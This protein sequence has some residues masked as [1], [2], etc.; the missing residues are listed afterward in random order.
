MSRP[1]YEKPEDRA[2]ERACAIAFHRHLNYSTEQPEMVMVKQ[3]DSMRF[4]YIF[5]R[6]DEQRAIMEHKGR[7]ED[8]EKYSTWYVSESKILAC[9]EYAATH[10]LP[11]YML[12]SWRATVYYALLKPE[13]VLFV[14]VNGNK[15]RNDGMGDVE[16]VCHF[17]RKLFWRFHELDPFPVPV[18]YW[19][20]EPLPYRLYYPPTPIPVHLSSLEA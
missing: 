3:P 12:F 14:D 10:N 13:H 9:F 19:D 11:F 7:V 1:K 17:H 5:R 20:A 15:G 4:D 18:D 16:R 2:L 8:S 6:R